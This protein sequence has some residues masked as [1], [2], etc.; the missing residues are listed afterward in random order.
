MILKI[1][2]KAGHECTVQN[3]AAHYKRGGRGT[4][5]LDE[6]CIYLTKDIFYVAK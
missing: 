6:V 5:I 2:P 1:F 4:A 3:L